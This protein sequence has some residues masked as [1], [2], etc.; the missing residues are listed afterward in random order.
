ML[1]RILV[2]EMVLL[3]LSRTCPESRLFCFSHLI[4]V[5]RLQLH[6]GL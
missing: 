3:L 2:L 1:K 4:P 5:G 6:K